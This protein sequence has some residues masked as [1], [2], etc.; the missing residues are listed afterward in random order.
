MPGEYWCS[1]ITRVWS[2][3]QPGMKT[4]FA[5]MMSRPAALLRGASWRNGG[6]HDKRGDLLGEAVHVYANPRSYRQPFCD[7]AGR[8]GSRRPSI[9]PAGRPSH[10]GLACRLDRFNRDLPARA[11]GL[12]DAVSGRC[13]GL[14]LRLGDR[15]VER[16]L[17]H[18]LG[19]DAL[20]YDGHD[21]GIRQIATLA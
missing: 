21:R 1:A 12:E 8:A 19:S 18:V 11:M 2:P 6:R 20:Q 9:V 7:L 16:R 13:A 10:V 4:N 14:S 5:F 17:D 15:G 3:R